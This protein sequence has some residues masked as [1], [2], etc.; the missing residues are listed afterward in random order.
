M[1]IVEIEIVTEAEGETVSPVELQVIADQLGEVFGGGPASTWVR[2]RDL[3]KTRYA[4]N[5]GAGDVLPVFV[6]VLQYEPP[7]L[8]ERRELAAEIA[9]VV[10]GG[11]SR[12]V[13]NT[14]VVFEPPGK[15]RVAFGGNLRD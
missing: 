15:G 14:H 10:A 13:Q 4:E 6:S 12:P 7:G 1:P 11:L 8:P 2:V 3:P 5:G 9:E